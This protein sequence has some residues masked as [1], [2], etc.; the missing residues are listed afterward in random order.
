MHQ[1]CSRICS[2]PLANLCASIDIGKGIAWFLFL[3]YVFLCNPYLRCLKRGHQLQ[4]KYF[5]LVYC[6]SQLKLP[7][8]CILTSNIGRNAEIG[9]A[10][11]N[12]SY[13]CPTAFSES[14]PYYISTKLQ[15]HLWDTRKCPFMLCLYVNQSSLWINMTENWSLSAVFSGSS[16]YHI[17]RMHVQWLGSILGT[18]GVILLCK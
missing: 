18:W 1:L 7:W 14:L 12:L 2:W 9:S 3:S 17:W 10:L 15:S 16:P 5:S 8:E 4:Y 6:K 11:W 13:N